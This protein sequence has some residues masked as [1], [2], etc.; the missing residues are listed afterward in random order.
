MEAGLNTL[1]ASAPEA[2][3]LMVLPTG[4]PPLAHLKFKRQKKGNQMLIIRLIMTS[5][6]RALTD[7]RFAF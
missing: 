3:E 2:A 6:K 4:F 5:L 7:S 1:L